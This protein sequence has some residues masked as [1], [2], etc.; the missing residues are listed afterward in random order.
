VSGPERLAFGWTVWAALAIGW[1]AYLILTHSP[2]WELSCEIFTVAL[3]IGM[4][5]FWGTR[6]D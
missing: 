3:A 6:R 5:I 1:L 2:P 4:A